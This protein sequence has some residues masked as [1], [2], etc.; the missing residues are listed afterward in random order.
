MATIS[1]VKQNP[2]LSGMFGLYLICVHCAY[3][4]VLNFRFEWLVDSQL[5]FKFLSFPELSVLCDLIIVPAVL[6]AFLAHK[7]PK[8]ALLGALAMCALGLLAIRLW[9]PKDQ[10]GGLATQVLAFTRMLSPLLTGLSLV[11][12]IGILLMLWRV[13]QKP[14]K[15]PAIELML[16]PLSKILGHDSKILQFFYAEQRIWIYALSRTLPAQSDFAGDLHF[17]YAKQNSNASTMLGMCIA[18]LLPTPILHWIIAQFSPG[19]AWF[20][21][22]LVLL[23]SLFM[24]AEYR[25]TLARPVSITDDTL[26]LRYGTLT[27]RK[28]ARDQIRSA[29]TLTWKD[30]SL[31]AKRYQGCGGANVEIV[32]DG[33]VIHLGL[34]EPGRFVAALNFAKL[35]N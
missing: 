30:E 8:Q 22:A 21:T 10:L 13:L 31:A 26:F 29:R 19:F 3:A 4:L 24:W 20:T 11:A 9:F 35:L 5:S 12:E 2:V 28:I 14:M 1:N 32:L 15:E 34:D 33:E 16:A 23:T 27:D 25:A 17:G 7:Q 18:N 6:Y